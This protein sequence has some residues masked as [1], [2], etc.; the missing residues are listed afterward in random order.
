[1]KQ[2]DKF[3]E[4]GKELGFNHVD[5]YSPKGKLVA[6]TFS[7]TKKYINSLQNL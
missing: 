4:L 2:L 6:V 1:M 3:I 7:R 5:V